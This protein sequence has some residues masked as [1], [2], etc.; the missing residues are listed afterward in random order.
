MN[1]VTSN[2][3]EKLQQHFERLSEDVLSDLKGHEELNLNLS[4][5]DQEYVRF[6]NS[7][8]RQATAVFQKVLEITYQ[9]QGRKIDFTLD[10]SGNLENDR[11]A[12]SSL[13]KRAREEAL[14]L[15]E[16]PF[17]VSMK[18][19]EAT[20]TQ[21]RGDLPTAE[22]V[23][24]EVT[25]Q[26]EGTDFT[27]LLACGPQ[28]RAIRNSKGL[29]HW[30][31]TESFFLDFSMYTVNADG[32]NKAVKHNYADQ[33]WH[34]EK[35][36]TLVT[37]GRQSLSLL[38]R[39]TMK[40]PAKGYRVYFSPKAVAEMARMFSWGALSYA[41]YRK[42]NSALQKLAAGQESFSPLFSLS[43]D[44]STGFVPRFN[45][46]GEV[47][48]EKTEMISEGKLKNWLVS[49]RAAKEYG[50]ESN[51]A[52]VNSWFGEYM[53]AL[54]IAPGTLAE[55]QALKELDTGLYLSNL[56]YINWSDVQNARIT[57]MT[58]YACFWVENGEIRAPIQDLRF[59]ESLYR[60]FGSELENLTQNA[61][62]DPTVDSYGLRALG[63]D[64]IPG[65]LVRDF[66]FTL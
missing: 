29:S 63:A 34:S 50:V 59:D 20:S 62:I 18:N 44:F 54:S 41:S 26:T 3:T 24:A 5:E 61:V 47:A 56:H 35:F 60:I 32:E 45:A 30:F 64:R 4:A 58:R 13:V 33:K 16:D 66:R 23:I 42:G 52:A 10:L 25:D 57:G 12:V 36:K 22:Q 31:S 37:S 1:S 38:K 15:P 2:E 51:G 53:R 21:K 28:M 17:I 49:S 48:P 27:G 46:E 43:E 65:A 8:V 9:N 55:S 39:P 11:K 6:N 40:L 7:K 14:V 19:G